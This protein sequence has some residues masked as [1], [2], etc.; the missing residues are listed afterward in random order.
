MFT[1]DDFKRGAVP[2]AVENQ[3]LSVHHDARR[4]LLR[5]RRAF[6]ALLAEL[7]DEIARPHHLQRAIG[8]DKML[9][10][11]IWKVIHEPEIFDA[12]PHLP[13]ASALGRF[14]KAMELHG[15]G[16]AMVED[17]RGAISDFND[18]VQLHAGDRAVFDMMLAASTD[19]AQ[20]EM[21]RAQQR[22]A[23]QANSFLWGIQAHAQ[24]A[25]AIIHPND[26]DPDRVDLV[27]ARGFLRLRR[28]K[29]DLPW[30]FGR[31]RCVS[32]QDDGSVELSAT[33]IDPPEPGADGSGLP[34]VPL[35]RDFCTSPIPVVRRTLSKDGFIE[36]TLVGT[37][38]GNTAAT[39]IIVAD[40][41][42]SAAPRYT[43]D[44][45]R[46]STKI[47][48]HTPIEHL[49]LDLLLHRDLVP[50]EPPRLAVFSDLRH[51]G[52]VPKLT[53]QQ[54]KPSGAIY[55]LGS[56][57][58]SVFDPDWPG[59]AKLVDHLLTKLKWDAAEF[60]VY[61]LRMEHPIMP[62]LVEVSWP[63]QRR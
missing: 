15:A 33:P 35:L 58:E 8:I 23:F 18:V 50:D 27:S 49:Y 59:C 36:D 5:V 44:D 31:F 29:D 2:E 45:G 63:L 9:A 11:R 25:T 48:I 38:A 37:P 7:G 14:F 54:L 3:G 61:R 6:G 60:Q 28:I 62:S 21:S 24:V 17:A 41:G 39:D 30:T 51:T 10:W 53:H 1:H 16:S 4:A 55:H 20:Q 40:L 22:A 34:P 12:V 57:A 32:H 26:D 43:A 56:A 42:A 47:K 46:A 13:Q 19:N 52:D